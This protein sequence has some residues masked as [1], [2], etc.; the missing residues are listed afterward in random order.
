MGLN[1]RCET[2]Q[3]LPP[4]AFTI[5]SIKPHVLY[6]AVV[7]SRDLIILATAGVLY[8]AAAR[9]NCRGRTIKN[10]IAAQAPQ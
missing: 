8:P 2:S 6:A 1:S 4:G 7:L 10:A 5:V 9:R 3:D